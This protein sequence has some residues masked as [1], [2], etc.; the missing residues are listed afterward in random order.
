MFL[1]ENE[2]A[3]WY[4]MFFILYKNFLKSSDMDWRWINSPVLF[5]MFFI[6]C[7]MS[8][9]VVKVDWL[10]FCLY[11]ILDVILFLNWL[12]IFMFYW[13]SDMSDCTL[14]AMDEINDNDNDN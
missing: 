13:L 9:I 11:V 5:L 3:I 6:L 7:L 10:Y 4:V 8:S 12:W 1:R 2:K 14:A